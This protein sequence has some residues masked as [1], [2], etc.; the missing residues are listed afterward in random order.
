M[1][2]NA[3]AIGVSVQEVW[4]LSRGHGSCSPRSI[5]IEQNVMSSQLYPESPQVPHPGKQTYLHRKSP[6]LI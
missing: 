1:K 4:S 5:Y 3:D 6:H 2:D